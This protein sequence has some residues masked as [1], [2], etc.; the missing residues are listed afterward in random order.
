MMHVSLMQQLP[1]QVPLVHQLPIIPM[2]QVSHFFYPYNPSLEDEMKR[3]FHFKVDVPTSPPVQ[4][5]EAV[6]E[7][8]RHNGRDFEYCPDGDNAVSEITPRRKKNKKPAATECVFCKNNGEMESYYRQHTL[9]YEDGR[10]SCPVLRAYKC[11]ICGTCGDDAHTI[12]Y[13][14]KRPK[15]L[16]DTYQ[17]VNTFKFLKNSIGKRRSK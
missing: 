12:K 4:N 9:K 14:P 10:V 2:P 1:M 3:L 7:E 17:T 5:V 13:C 6:M 11:P 16:I 8:F 15:G